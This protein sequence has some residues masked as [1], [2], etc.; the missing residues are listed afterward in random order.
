MKPTDIYT[1]VTN[2]IISLLKEHQQNF[3]Q[4]WI[5]LDQDQDYARNPTTGNYYQ[6]INQFLLC[7]AL[8]K[9]QYTKNMWLTFKKAQNMKAKVKK[10]AKSLPIIFYKTAHIDDCRSNR[11]ELIHARHIFP[12]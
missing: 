2:Q 1:S 5:S 7:I 9:K 12:G 3:D 4:P 10:G 6:G 8:R 11:G